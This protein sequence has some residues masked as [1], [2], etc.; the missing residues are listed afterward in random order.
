MRMPAGDGWYLFGPMVAVVLVC[1][2]CWA[3]QPLWA[4]AGDRDDGWDR[5]DLDVG[6]WI[7]DSWSGDDWDAGAGLAI[8]AEPEHSGLLDT[9]AI[10]DDREIACEMLLLLRAAGIRATHAIRADGRVAVL[11][12]PEHVDEARRLVGDTP[13]R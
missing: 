6:R 12:F 11:V 4:G 1:G 3:L 8:F 10:T 13:A 2:L 5:A 9:A 7:T